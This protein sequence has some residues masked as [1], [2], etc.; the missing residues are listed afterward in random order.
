MSSIYSEASD[1]S[2]NENEGYSDPELDELDDFLSIQQANIKRYSELLQ[3][4][5]ITVMDFNRG[6]LDPDLYFHTLNKIN[7]EIENIDYTDAETNQALVEQEI[8]FQTLLDEY[9]RKIETI[10]KV[11]KKQ[12]KD[13]LDYFEIARIEAIQHIIEKI[14][15][16]YVPEDIEPIDVPDINLVDIIQ[17]RKIE[18]IELA[19]KK[20]M[21]IPQRSSFKNDSEFQQAEFTFYEKI[22]FLLPGI[23]TGFEIFE[24]REQKEIISLAKRLKIPIPKNDRTQFY[25]EVSQL[26]PGYTFIMNPTKIGYSYELLNIVSLK[27]KIQNDIELLEQLPVRISEIELEQSQK[28]RIL[29][30]ILGKM[31]KKDLI[32]CIKVKVQKEEIVNIPKSQTIKLKGVTSEKSETNSM[33]PQQKENYHNIVQRK[34]LLL[35]VLQK[36]SL[37]QQK[38][39]LKTI[40]KEKIEKYKNVPLNILESLRKVSKK[41][42]LNSLEYNI[43]IELKVYTQNM[44]DKIEQYVFKISSNNFISYSNKIEDVLFIFDNY[45]SF[46]TKLLTGKINMY[47]VILFEKELSEEA[48]LNIYPVNIANRKIILKQIQSECNSIGLIILKS[49]I[50]TKIAIERKSKTFEIMIFEMSKT[51]KDYFY[52]AKKL[53]DIISLKGKDVLI[54]NVSIMDTIQIQK[55]NEQEYDVLTQKWLKVLGLQG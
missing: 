16:Q 40:K 36:Y 43:P 44:I 23:P 49:K 24:E 35:E 9:I 3:L 2:S 45:P 42:L 52:N 12:T 47:Q 26:L 6:R 46:K 8:R 20:G 11:R 39:F 51:Q 37:F 15:L 29:Y 54:G 28:K 41:R 5:Y 30:D 48:R 21:I 1:K 33:D 17:T 31:E 14:Q 53:I 10:R 25:S 4:K 7:T 34:K 19:G 55:I 18:L 50:L 32:D 13:Y 27:E 22:Y 38:K